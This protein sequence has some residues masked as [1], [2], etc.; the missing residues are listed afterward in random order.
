LRKLCRSPQA[1]GPSCFAKVQGFDLYEDVIYG[2]LDR[3][4]ACISQNAIRGSK[5]DRESERK[6]SR[7]SR[8]ACFSVRPAFAELKVFAGEHMGPDPKKPWCARLLARR[9]PP[10][11]LGL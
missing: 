1:L 10:T 3:P 8:K 9:I 5:R 2:S 7:R 4:R 11:K 6:K